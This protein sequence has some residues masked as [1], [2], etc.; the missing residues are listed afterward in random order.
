MQ[1]YVGPP[2]FVGG[3]SSEPVG[4]WGTFLPAA[5]VLHQWDYG[6]GDGKMSR[7][8][9]LPVGDP[10]HGTVHAYQYW[11]CR[12]EQCR[13]AVARKHRLMYARRRQELDRRKKERGAK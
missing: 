9:E 10:R 13:A 12:C 6:G 4:R 2:A 1:R 8:G 7:V 3:W 5:V 11:F